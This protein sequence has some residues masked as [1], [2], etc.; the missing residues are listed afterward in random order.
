MARHGSVKGLGNIHKEKDF[1]C[2]A[3]GAAK[4]TRASH[5][6]SASRAKQACEL[7]HTDL[8]CPTEDGLMTNDRSYVLTIL[9]DYSR[10]S[11]VRILGTK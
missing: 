9:D 3:C 10:Y 2:D 6:P 1:D 4:Q 7:I 5:H 8:M 11:E